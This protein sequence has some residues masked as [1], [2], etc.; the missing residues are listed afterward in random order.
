MDWISLESDQIIIP[1]N[2]QQAI[3]GEIT[4][5]FSA[6]GTYV[7]ALMV[8]PQTTH[9]SGQ[10][11]FRYRY[12]VRIIIN[13]DR[14]GSLPDLSVNSLQ[15]EK[16]D[17]NLP[18]VRAT[19]LNTSNLLY[20]LAAEMTIRD[21]NRTLVERIVFSQDELEPG[22]FRNMKIYPEAELWLDGRINKPL[23]PGI[24]D[25]RLF[26]R[27]ANGRQKVQSEKLVVQAGDFAYSVDDI[28][29]NIEPKILSATIRSGAAASQVL[30]LT[31][32]S[33]KPIT[34]EIYPK[35]IV[36]DYPY[37]VFTATTVEL[38]APEVVEIAP[39]R[40]ARAVLITRSPRDTIA[41][42]YYGYLTVIA[43]SEDEKLL[44][45][46]DVLIKSI[47]GDQFY[48]DTEIRSIA[49]SSIGESLLLSA[50][51]N[52]LSTVDINPTAVVYLKDDSGVIIRTL[53]LDLQEG[54]NQ[55]LP[56]ESG[57]LIIDDWQIE[58]GEYLAEIRVYSGNTE[59]GFSEQ[60]VLVP[61]LEEDHN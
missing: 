29:L 27:Y 24:Y 57:Y 10:V 36:P 45:T 61:Y 6:A 35:D 22:E 11:T 34:V 38:R 9:V 43:R 18:F 2:E 28:Y 49:I 54:V 23:F 20:P 14:P 44:S 13:V 59:I 8:E 3:R 16:D 48:Y 50:V 15:I 51:V 1:P 30:E 42:G 25:L 12:A 4:V 46:Q 33:N 26:V 55:I 41:G 39:R 19:I 17:E 56:L 32:N 5:P 53:R 58:A 31:N 52:N 7:L 40:T 37:S 47:I 60:N 21:Q